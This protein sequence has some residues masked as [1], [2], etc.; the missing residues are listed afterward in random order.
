VL[1][2]LAAGVRADPGVEPLSDAAWGGTEILARISTPSFPARTYS[3]ADF[4]A[5]PGADSTAAIRA[6]VAACSQAGGGRVLIPPGTWLTGA[7][8]LASNVELHVS[9]GAKLLFSTD[10]S[11]YSNVPTRFEGVECINYSPLIYAE[12][13]ENVAVTGEGTLDGQASEENWWGWTK[14]GARLD[15]EDREK[16][17]RMG[18]DGVPVERRVFGPGHHLRPSFIE[19]LRCQRVLVEGVRIVRSP[20]WEIHPAL[21]RDVIVRG[22]DILSHGPNND[23]CDPECCRDV[24]IEHCT[25]D[26]GDDCI[27]IK[28]GRNN[29]GRRVGVPSEDLLVRGCTM[30]DGHGGVVI[31]SE[32]SG[33]CRNVYVEDCVMDSPRLNYALRIKSNAARGGVL[34]NIFMR[35]VRVGSVSDAVLT[36]DLLYEEGARGG[37][38]PVV[39]NIW[40]GHVSSAD[41]PHVVTIGSFEGAT[42]TDV[43]IRDSAFRGVT[44]AEVEVGA[45]PVDMQG[46]SIERGKP[47][48]GTP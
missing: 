5:S 24:L 31:G 27:A 21:S 18:E 1:G 13:A 8:R 19:F 43:H 2:A 7:I 35:N 41:S 32:I 39:R 44:Q 34:E 30:R 10:P 23:G 29:D 45:G 4:G 14:R 46:V 9:K 17:F 12:S 28:S 38:P 20:M 47:A 36:I 26:T 40:L 16:L 11:A 15:R 6:A 33:G 42:V 48:H 22:V 25:F 37:H 3:I